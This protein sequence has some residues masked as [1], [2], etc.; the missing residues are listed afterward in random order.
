[1]VDVQALLEASFEHAPE[2]C[3]FHQ[4]DLLLVKSKIN[5]LGTVLLKCWMIRIS[6]LLEVWLK[7]FCCI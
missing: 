6:E 5:G 3:L 4:R 2:T 1:V 7:E